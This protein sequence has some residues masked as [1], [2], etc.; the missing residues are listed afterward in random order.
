MHDASTANVK[1]DPR[2]THNSIFPPKYAA[3]AQ[4]HIRA[5]YSPMLKRAKSNFIFQSALFLIMKNERIWNFV[6]KGSELV[7][8]LEI[9]IFLR[10]VAVVGAEKIDYTE[11]CRGDLELEEWAI[12]IDIWN[13]ISKVEDGVYCDHKTWNTLKNTL[14]YMDLTCLNCEETRSDISKELS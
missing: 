3:R 9:L 8:H 13:R 7:L 12:Y 2:T 5:E 1:S 10:E 4:Q 14:I 6:G 11:T